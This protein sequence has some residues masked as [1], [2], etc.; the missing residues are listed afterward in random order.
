MK[1]FFVLGLAALGVQPLLAARLQVQ[2]IT[3]MAFVTT[4]QPCEE[5]VS[6]RYVPRTVV[7][8]PGSINLR[9]TGGTPPYSI[10]WHDGSGIGIC[11]SAMPGR[12]TVTVIDALGERV[13][14]SI[15]VGRSH[16]TVQLHCPEPT[17]NERVV[18]ASECK[19]A[20]KKLKP[21]GTPPRK[22]KAERLLDNGLSTEGGGRV[23]RTDRRK[24]DGSPR[25]P[26]VTRR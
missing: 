23:V 24:G 4:I 5:D 20:V 12:R 1:A 11:A 22:L 2:Y 10:Q 16:R 8:Q 25:R 6:E 17:N 13:T 14:R 9:I 7:T 15:H 21:I 19:P 26:I 18:S 3:T